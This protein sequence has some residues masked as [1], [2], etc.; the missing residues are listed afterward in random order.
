MILGKHGTHAHSQYAGSKK[1]CEHDCGYDCG[2]HCCSLG[3]PA[4]VVE[5]ERVVEKAL[6]LDAVNALVVA[7]VS[8]I[9]SEGNSGG[10]LRAMHDGVEKEA[11][12]LVVNS[13]GPVTDLSE[14]VSGK[15][16][17]DYPFDL[18]H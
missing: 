14:N 8:Q 6:L 16:D 15:V 12:V 17:P 4:A 2:I 9:A 5:S 11:V 3:T 10:D 13:E 1:A 7:A 18:P